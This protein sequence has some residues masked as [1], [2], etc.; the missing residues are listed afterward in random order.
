MNIV[1]K[2]RQN[3]SLNMSSAQSNVIFSIKFIFIEIFNFIIFYFVSFEKKNS[4]RKNED[5]KSW[6]DINE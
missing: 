4:K 1:E 5:I 6:T 3:P 2:K